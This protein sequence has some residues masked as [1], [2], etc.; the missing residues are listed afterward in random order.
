MS[1]LA[2]LYAVVALVRAA[3]AVFIVS[4]VFTFPGLSSAFH[5]LILASYALAEGLSGFLIGGFYERFGVRSTL[6]FATFTLS[7]SYLAMTLSGSPLATLF[8]NSLNGVMAAGVLVASLSALA[9]ETRGRPLAR[10]LGSGGFEASNLG[11]YALGFIV[12]LLLE[13]LGLLEGFLTSTILSL[14]A[15]LLAL[16]S[17]KGGG[18]AVVFSIERRVLKLAPLWFGLASLMG[19]AFM[20]PKIFKEAG[21]TIVGLDKGEGGLSLTLIVGLV[22]VAVGLVVG[23][24]IASLIGKVRAVTLGVISIA[25]LLVIGGFYYN[26]LLKPSLLVFLAILAI[27]PMMLPPAMLALLA[28]YTDTARARGVQMGFYVTILA[29]GIAFGEFVLGGLIFDRLGLTATAVIAAIA[30]LILATP[31]IY[32]VYMDAKHR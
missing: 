31:T 4:L 26:V 5:G 14:L 29:F 13:L 27:P 19:L 22:A 24:Y 12:A 28:D 18:Q 1:G 10:I 25:V 32:L 21:I 17:P 11:G 20:A 8:L 15:L 16:A 23:S 6:L 9:E 30:F 3:N 2:S 7:M